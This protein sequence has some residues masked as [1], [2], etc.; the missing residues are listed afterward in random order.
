[1][2]Y[3]YKKEIEAYFSTPFGF[4]FMGIFL[5]LSGISFTTANLLGGN[6]DLSGMFGLLSSMSFM[7]FPILTMKLFAEERKAG[8]EQLLLTSRL[9]VTKIVLGKYFASLTV[10]AVTLLALIIYV[11]IIIT[12]GSPNMG[13]IV[14]SFIGFFLLGAAMIA[15]CLFAAS[16]AENQVTAAIAGFGI[17]FVLVMLPT[18]SNSLQ[19]PVLSDVLKAIAI[20][21]PYDEFVRGIFSIGP[22]CYYI[23]YTFVMLFLTVKNIQ[24]RRLA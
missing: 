22:V 11:G 7:T 10:F 18:F 5:L 8:T 24:R 12:Y 4:I 19:V 20:S 9:S 13:S 1:M 21:S 16:F 23:G 14:A 6:G 2:G 17:L 15:V 3:L